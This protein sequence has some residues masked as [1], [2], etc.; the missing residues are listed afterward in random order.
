MIECN[1]RSALTIKS[2]KP[3]DAVEVRFNPFSTAGVQGFVISCG[4]DRLRVKVHATVG[5]LEVS[6]AVPCLNWDVVIP[7]TSI[8]LVR[9]LKDE[10][11][12]CACRED[13][14]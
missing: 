14:P 6:D 12:G 2:L 8:T 11:V 5:A 4:P 9:H 13:L 3:G 7:W 10:A 1:D